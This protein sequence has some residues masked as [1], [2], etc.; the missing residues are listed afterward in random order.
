MKN[1]RALLRAQWDRALALAFILLG[2]VMLL[3]G[4]LG[5]SAADY[6]EQQLSYIASGGLGG[7]VL[8]GIGVGLLVSADLHDEWRKLDRIEEAV[9]R[10]TRPDLDVTLSD[11][12]RGPG[13][14]AADPT[15]LRQAAPVQASATLAVDG[16][17]QRPAMLALAGLLGALALLAA[18]W[19]R[20][21]AAGDFD[22]A[23]GGTTLGLLGVA[24]AIFGVGAY[25][26]GARHRFVS[27]RAQ[28]LS[29]WDRAADPEA[30]NHR[31]E[32]DATVFV[33]AGQRH[34]HRQ[35]CMLLQKREVTAVPRTDVDGQRQACG[36]CNPA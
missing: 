29:R 30:V 19:V 17:F 11:R 16:T 26:V 3:L 4:Y 35:G 23:V 20:T 24:V 21:S 28:L 32:P 14:R 13:G 15:V 12:G 36:L 22:A 8:I 10:D 25:L 1:L 31:T 33:V 5:V 27:R 2:G 34:Y 18:G 7:V 9:R 6:A